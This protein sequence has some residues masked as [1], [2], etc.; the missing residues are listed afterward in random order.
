MPYGASPGSYPSSS[1]ATAEAEG[2]ANVGIYD[3]YFQSNQI[4]VPIGTTVRWTNA[5]RHQHTVT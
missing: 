4:T 3:N 1:Y 5:G 2:T